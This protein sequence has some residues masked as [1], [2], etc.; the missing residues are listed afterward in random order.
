MLNISVRN[1]KYNCDITLEHKVTII[2]GDSGRGKTLLVK[3]LTDLSG[4][5]KVTYSEPVKVYELT[6]RTWKDI[7]LSEHKEK[8]LLIIDECDFARTAEFCNTFSRVENCYL[9]CMIRSDDITK[10]FNDLSV[11]CTTKD[12][13]EF[14]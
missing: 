2:T 9:M 5:Y 7:L 3:S 4:G 12:I 1:K 14:Y 11:D 8:A 6:E 13:E 10:L